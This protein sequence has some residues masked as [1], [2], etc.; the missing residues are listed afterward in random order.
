MS[1]QDLAAIEPPAATSP[2][3]SSEPV[4]D[5]ALSKRPRTSGLLNSL[6]QC[7]FG[8]HSGPVSPVQ[9]RPWVASAERAER[10]TARWDASPA[11]PM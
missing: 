1:T 9:H 8:N 10:L 2:A 4:T 11:Q 3:S 6:S 5:A 7:L